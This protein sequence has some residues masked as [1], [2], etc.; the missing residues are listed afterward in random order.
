MSAY[1]GA[2][3][4]QFPDKGVLCAQAAA[5]VAAGLVALNPQIVVPVIVAN[6]ATSLLGSGVT[7]AAIRLGFTV[8]TE[9]KSFSENL[10]KQV[11]VSL[12]GARVV[13][14]LVGSLFGVTLRVSVL[15]TA[16]FGMLVNGSMAQHNIGKPQAFCYLPAP[17]LAML[18]ARLK[19]VA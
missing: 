7:A 12:L 14:P 19:C 13:V 18:A 6:I 15:A 4:N 2:I 1:L 11:F 9:E 10:I 8:E 17:F 16:I 3:C 5:G